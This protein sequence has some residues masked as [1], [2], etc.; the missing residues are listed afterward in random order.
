[1]GVLQQLESGGWDDPSR[2]SVIRWVMQS[3]GLL[4]M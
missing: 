3:D 1:M 2:S 4:K